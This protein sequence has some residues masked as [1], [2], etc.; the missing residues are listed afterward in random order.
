MRS[1]RRD[2]SSR[3]ERATEVAGRTMGELTID[4]VTS[5]GNGRRR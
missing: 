4:T 1:Q 3:D 2:S 5:A